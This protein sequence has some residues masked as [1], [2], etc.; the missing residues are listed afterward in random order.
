MSGEGPEIAMLFDRSNLRAQ[1]ATVGALAV[2]LTLTACGSDGAVGGTSVPEGEAETMQPSE[3]PPP[4][5]ILAA[6]EPRESRLG[7][8]P[9]TVTLAVP[10]GVVVG[11]TGRFWLVV[12]D[13]RQLRRG[14]YYQV[15]LN[16]PEGQRPDPAAASFVGNISL[17]GME[18]E[19]KEGAEQAFDVTEHLR[20]SPPEELRVTFVRGNPGKD[21]S[22]DDAFVS[23]RR[24]R[25]ERRP[26]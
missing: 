6:T 7:N 5:E 15:Y 25:L 17:Y 9:T 18:R 11:E 12:E 22:P 16:L 24:V 2:A 20:S 10:F 3:T 23:F 19:S 1:P 21:A 4:P 8:A 26:D 14:A 13:L